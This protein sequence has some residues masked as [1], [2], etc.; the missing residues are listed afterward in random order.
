MNSPPTIEDGR[1][2]AEEH[3]S[4]FVRFLGHERFC[5]KSVRTAE[6]GA[7]EAHF[8]LI[9]VNR[10]VDYIRLRNGKRQLWVNV[11]RL[12][13]NPEKYH[14][15]LDVEAYANI[16]ID[17]DAKKPDDRKDFA[18]TKKERGFALA[19]L[20]TVQRWLSENGFMPG[21]AFESGN[22]AGLLLPIPPTPP[23]PEF[24]AKV[25][26]FL[27]TVKRSA[28]VDVD[29][30]TFDPGRVCG[31]LQTWNSKL[32]D[33]AEGRK[34]RLRVAIGD[35]PTRDED[36]ALLRHIEGLTP[37][38]DALKTWTE[39]FN[40]PPTAGGDEDAEPEPQ[41]DAGEIDVDFV[42]EK[43]DTLLEAD[44]TL[45]SLLDW[46][47]EA[48]ERHD[49]D[50]SDAEFG[51]VGKLTGAGFT[52]P[53]INWIMTYISR[54][55]K[56]SEEGEHYQRLTLRKIRAKDAEETAEDEGEGA[57]AT[58]PKRLRFKDLMKTVTD[59]ETGKKRRQRSVTAAATSIIKKY[60]IISTPDGQIWVYDAQEGIWKPNG[61]TLVA[62]ELD[63]AGNDATNITF[64]R[65]VTQKVFLRTLDE[66]DGDI[67]NPDPDL[68][69]VE[70]GIIDLRKGLDGFMPHDPKYKRT[71]KSPIVF[72]PKAKCPEIEKYL[73]SSLDE[74]GRETLIDVMAAK[75]S[76]YVFNY[77]SPWVGTGRNGK[78]M[79]AEII[80][81]IWG[82][83]LITEV[84]VYKLAERRFDQIALRGKRWIF[85]SETPRTATKTLF[86]WAKKI[87]GG[88]M[89]T[90]DQKNKE[91][92]QFRT[93][94]YFV[95][96]CNSAPRIGESTRAIEERIAPI[97]WPYTFVDNPVAPEERKADRHL[98]G[99]ITKP[100][101]LSGFLNVLLLEAPRLIE[102]RIIRRTGTGKEIV[103]AYNLKADHLAMFWD[104]VVSYSPGNV[105]PS[106][107]MYNGY[108]R[109]CE[110]IKVS[111]ET[112]VG[113]NRY[114]Q[115]IGFRKGSPR[116][117][118]DDGRQVQVKGWYDCE[119][120]ESELEDLI[121]PKD[122]EK[123]DPPQDDDKGDDEK[124]Q[125]R[126]TDVT[127][128]LPVLENENQQHVTDVT[129]ITTLDNSL[130]DIED[131]GNSPVNCI[132]EVVDETGKSGKIGNK[133]AIPT[134]NI[135]VTCP[136]KNG[137]I[138]GKTSPRPVGEKA[139]DD[140]VFG[141]SRAYYLQV[142]GGQIPTIRQ[143]MDDIPSEWTADKAKMA[144]HLL[145]E[146]GDSRGFNMPPD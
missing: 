78:L 96:D 71:W 81:G 114:G 29:E 85:N 104:R 112:L 145:E 41:E 117:S 98:L 46:T 58:D 3:L 8:D 50:R 109:L 105:T 75:L 64:T 102:T 115:R 122:D 116:V 88:D 7:D 22:G 59:E 133:I 5:I 60:D 84:E 139:K 4:R 42:R 53:E 66:T 121:G 110:A 141:K 74:A 111:P 55:G 80:R 39:K 36:K 82:S 69:P 13:K 135:A 99:K 134:G 1:L 17:I 128:M 137:N 68:F 140:G 40:Q 47:D 107:V 136:P 31:I 91:H 73:A 54:I 19:Q 18:A 15:H 67:F 52:D 103:E 126:V 90:A 43:L 108:K 70:N 27:K 132:K 62:A 48:K 89:I 30:T 61:R 124:K 97:F 9:N 16:F 63:H 87:S 37:D 144:I 93:D 95:F 65:E 123:T 79:A 86:D 142:G 10:A 51:L 101:E 14:T 146:K 34:N 44:P 83:P 72:D 120:D 130:K 138:A 6:R 131:I 57:G 56:W 106:T 20:P 129:D 127:G 24:I 11:Q 33:E 77:F 2:A 35:I 26:T 125:E 119:I 100:E 76:G 113:F 49:G 38:P 32:E 28:N 23:T 25:A 143:L 12:K 92:V 21:L 94:A 45:Q 118:T